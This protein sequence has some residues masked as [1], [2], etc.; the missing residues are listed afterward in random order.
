[1]EPNL[2][3]DAACERGVEQAAGDAGMGPPVDLGTHHVDQVSDLI[4]ASIKYIARIGARL[5]VDGHAGLDYARLGLGRTSRQDGQHDG[6]RHIC[7]D[8]HRTSSLES[9]SFMSYV[10]DEEFVL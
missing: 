2:A 5:L 6:R 3:P 7:R 8:L 4:G 10:I 9:T 1:M